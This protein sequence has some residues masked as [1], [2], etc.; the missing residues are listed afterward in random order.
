MALQKVRRDG[1]STVI[2][3]PPEV[4]AKLDLSL[5]TYVEV[6]ADEERGRIIVAPVSI[7]PRARRDFSEVARK[8]TARNRGLHARLE[9]YDRGE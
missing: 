9:R 7:Q 2:T 6:E 4:V 8:V 3:L 1:N 5:G